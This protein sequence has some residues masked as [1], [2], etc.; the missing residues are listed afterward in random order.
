MAYKNWNAW[1]NNRPSSFE[2]QKV[3]CGWLLDEVEAWLATETEEHP[4]WYLSADGGWTRNGHYWHT[5]E[6]AN[7]F[8]NHFIN[9]KPSRSVLVFENDWFKEGF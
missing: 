9:T 7:E 5:E 2:C 4:Y 3:V 1:P 6:E 8:M